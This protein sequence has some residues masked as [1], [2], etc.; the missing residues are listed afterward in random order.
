MSLE[1]VKSTGTLLVTWF[2]GIFAHRMRLLDKVL[3]VFKQLAQSDFVVATFFA[4][5]S[6]Y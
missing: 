1:S 3:C 4:I 2:K 5:H 6:K